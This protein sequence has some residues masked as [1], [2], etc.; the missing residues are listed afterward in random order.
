MEKGGTIMKKQQKNW[1]KVW[2]ISIAL[3]CIAFTG[4][5]LS[6]STVDEINKAIKEAG[7]KWV[8]DETP[9]SFLSR[10]EKKMHLGLL[11]PQMA[12]P[13]GT[14]AILLKSLRSTDTLPR[15][16]DWRDVNG[17]NYVTP[18]KDQAYCG[19]CWAFAAT[20]V[21]ESC[22]LIAS[23][24][25]GIPLDLSEQVL[26]SCMGIT[27]CSGGYLNDPVTFFET[28]G[29]PKES[30]YP[31]LATDYS[32]SAC[33]AWQENTFKV[34][35]WDWVSYDTAAD[36]SA[37]KSAL[38]YQGPLMAA[39]LVF[40]DFYYYSSGVY[41]H[42]W[43]DYLGGHAVV[44]TGWDDRTQ[45][46]IVKNSWATDWGEAGFFRIAYSELSGDTN[47]GSETVAYGSVVVPDECMLTS[48]APSIQYV[49]R[50]GGSG[51]VQVK[52]PPSCPWT[53]QSNDSWITLTGGESGTGNGVVEYSATP[54]SGNDTR[55]GTLAIGGEVLTLIQG[56][57][58]TQ[59]ADTAG[60]NGTNT[61]LAVDGSGHVHISY[62]DITNRALKY[63]T[64]ASGAWVAETVDAEA[65]PGNY[66]TSIAVDTDGS[67]H[68][69]YYGG[70]DL[71]YATNRSGSWEKSI[72]DFPGDVGM[73]S[74]IALD[75]NGYAYISYYEMPNT[76]GGRLK[77][78]TNA[79]GT[80][81]VQVVD[82]GYDVGMYSSL[83][84]DSNGK[85][86]I[87]YYDY[88]YGDLKYTTNAGGT[89]SI[90]VIDSSGNAGA[91]SSLALDTG[92]NVHISY[93][94]AGAAELSG[95]LKYAS[96]AS[97][98]W[99]TETVDE[100]G[101]VG[102]YSSLAL[103]SN[104]KAHIS[105]Y[106]APT[107]DLKYADNASGSWKTEKV[108][109]E[110]DAGKYTS[111]AVDSEDHVHISYFDAT[112]NVLKYATDKDN[113]TSIYSLTVKMVGSGDGAV[114]SIP[115]GIACSGDCKG[116]FEKS[117]RV[118]L[119]AVP[120]RGVFTGWS[121]TECS[122][123]GPCTVTLDENKLVTATFTSLRR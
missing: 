70:L 23:G 52:A 32:C 117:T 62:Y 31:Y 73:Y 104:G 1:F 85:A 112:D 64:N 114:L 56:R 5:S 83:A 74:S 88:I 90:R 66:G 13:A 6:A 81:E 67:A 48:L 69:S 82:T 42:V 101:L 102:M 80:W 20:G 18:V 100:E 63:A 116:A 19:S 58:A 3:C 47:F 72:V 21:L 113:T 111:I 14:P 43:G 26:V 98:I 122:G 29:I 105:Y 87:S 84:L 36:L 115:E 33:A 77:F 37:I 4:P 107:R 35:G 12:P 60:D 7:A 44:I 95:A 17:E 61:S 97:G 41:S 106:S 78:A 38:Y 91:Y 24:T 93:Y 55:T 57:W 2:V 120:S 50:A 123:R 54:L 68:I 45:A 15:A 86:H 28:E 71:M 103:D 46:L 118:T 96:N 10:E 34:E 51:S 119:I 59:T 8:A 25:P 109:F 49:E 40:E 9:L 11:M 22:A 79:T 76:G 16:F 53:A 110:I 65:D 94:T 92:D 27:G 121:G 89:W 39:F 99:V 75:A 108:D 30:C